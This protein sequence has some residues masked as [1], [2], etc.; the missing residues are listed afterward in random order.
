MPDA[1][2]A[3][4]PEPAVQPETATAIPLTGRSVVAVGGP[5]RKTFLQGLVSNDVQAVG[6]ERAVYA[7]LLTPQGKYLFDFFIVERDEMLLL[8]VEA[9]RAEALLRR[10][11]PFKLR[12]K[13]TLDACG[14]TFAVVSLLPPDLAAAAVG[15]AG[16]PG[17]AAAWREGVVFVDPRLSALGLRALL[18][19]AD[20]AA[21]AL[22]GAGFAAGAPELYERLRLC[23]GVPDGDRDMVPEKATLLECN[24][25]R[26]NGVSWDKGCYMGQELTAR[27]HY[28]GLVKKRLL[29]VQIDGP[30]PAWGTP[31]LH[32]GREV[33]EMRSG[34][35]DRGLALLRLD[36]L[37]ALGDRGPGFEADAARLR[38]EWPAWLETS[39]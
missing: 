39:A 38:P 27:M 14:G 1:A 11:K 37:E 12:S 19:V 34:L 5:D 36:A 24:V 13:V 28:R 8:D 4:G 15:L 23:L 31:V 35:G 3:P 16:G 25:D 10:L 6:P 17:T 26:L 20:G 7:A 18:P 29:P 33:G 32:E 22:A 9:A 2:T 21:P 30:V